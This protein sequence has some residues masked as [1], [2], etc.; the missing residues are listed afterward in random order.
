MHRWLAFGAPT[1]EL[2]RQQWVPHPINEVFPF[3]ED[4]HNLARITPPWLG[5]QVTGIEPEVIRAGTRIAYR[6][7]WFGIPYRWRSLIAEWVPEERFVDTQIQGPYILWHHT[8]TF[9]SCRGGVLLNDRVRYRLPFGPIGSLLH[10]L[11]VRRQ[12]EAIFEFRV[13]KVAELF[14]DGSVFFSPPQNE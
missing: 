13:Q 3:F 1:F 9:E 8:H 14:C 2:A 5:F 11:L 10:R 7:Y 12:L 6:L 4:P